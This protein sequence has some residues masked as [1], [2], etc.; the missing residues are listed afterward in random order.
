MYDEPKGFGALLASM[1]DAGARGLLDQ[2][3]NDFQQLV[4]DQPQTLQS[5]LQENI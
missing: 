5:F 3:S 4:I 1:Y 2:E